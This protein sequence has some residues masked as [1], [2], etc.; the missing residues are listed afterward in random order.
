MVEIRNT[1]CDCG[2][3]VGSCA[4]REAANTS[5][6]AAND[7]QHCCSSVCRPLCRKSS[8]RHCA[9]LMLSTGATW[10]H[11][12]CCCWWRGSGLHI[13]LRLCVSALVLC[14]PRCLC[15][16]LCFCLSLLSVALVFTFPLPVCVASPLPAHV[17]LAMYLSRSFHARAAFDRFYHDLLFGSLSFP[18][19]TPK[20]LTIRAT[21]KDYSCLP[22][23]FQT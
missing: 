17:L 11:C 12:V 9:R 6:I 19:L 5:M 18:L 15:L 7:S 16:C 21:P 10:I 22:P 23:C 1:V 2:E 4:G 3:I 20:C 13:C 8:A 14:H